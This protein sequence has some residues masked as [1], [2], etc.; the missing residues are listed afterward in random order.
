MRTGVMLST[1]EHLLAALRAEGLTDRLLPL[2]TQGAVEPADLDGSSR[3]L[4][5]RRKLQ[6]W[7]ATGARVS[8]LDRRLKQNPAYRF[9]RRLVSGGASNPVHHH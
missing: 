7:F 5:R 9:A 6:Q 4:R 2:P 3:A 1:V 8:R